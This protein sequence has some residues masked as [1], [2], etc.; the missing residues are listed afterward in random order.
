MSLM[1]RRILID[2]LDCHPCWLTT[3][4]RLPSISITSIQAGVRLL[5]GIFS[6]PARCR[7]RAMLSRLRDRLTA[8]PLLPHDATGANQTETTPQKS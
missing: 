7:A 2:A 6:T 5:N 4:T 1:V 3:K 8:L